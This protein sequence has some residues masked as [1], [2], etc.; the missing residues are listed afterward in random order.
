MTAP[1][2][3]TSSRYGNGGGNGSKPA[4]PPVNWISL[5]A[6]TW[7]VGAAAV[8][9]AFYLGG[10]LETPAEKQERIDRATDPLLVD[11]AELQRS[12]DRHWLLGGHAVMESRM[13]AIESSIE[14]VNEVEREETEILRE[15]SET[16]RRQTDRQ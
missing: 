4:R 1:K 3:A 5:L 12:I 11:L 16:L 7:V 10:R 13:K 2:R 8:G 9:L 14:A 15:I 6:F